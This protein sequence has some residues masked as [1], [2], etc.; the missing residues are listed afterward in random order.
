MA[1]NREGSALGNKRFFSFLFLLQCKKSFGMSVA[2]AFLKGLPARKSHVL[3]LLQ[4]V[5]CLSANE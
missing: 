3:E 2:D 1:G 4:I 5:I